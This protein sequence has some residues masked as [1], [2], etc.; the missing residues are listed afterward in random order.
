MAES[1]GDEDYCE[2]DFV[3]YR[4]REEWKDVTPIEQD[5]GP[6]ANYTVWHFR[7]VL[8]KSLNKDLQQELQYVSQVI[9][10][11]PKNYQVWYHRKVIVE[12]LK[13]PSEELQFTADILQLDAKNYHAWQHRQWVIKEF[14]LWEKELDYV[15][16]LLTEDLR[17]N[18]AWNQRYFVI[19]ET[20]GFIE[21]IVHREVRLTVDL[22]KKVPN[23][24]SAWNYLKGVLLQTGLSKYPGLKNTLL[25]M[26]SNGIDS[27][28]L[29]STLIDIYEEELERGLTDS[30]CLEQ[31]LELCHKLATDVD[32]IRREYW[33][34]ISR[35]LK[36][37]FGQPQ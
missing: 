31:A 14:S 26:Y 5:D 10:D 21:D 7:R 22:I 2:V 9:K 30:N 29:M 19:S 18:S 11:Q 4:D 1:S 24:E 16:K 27:P 8:L 15:D 3:F 37:K 20:T 23:N 25:E 28:Y 17:N 34:Y 13:D 12:W 6:S 35:S 36:S 33:H 32:L